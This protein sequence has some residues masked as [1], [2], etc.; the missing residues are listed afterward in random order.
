MDGGVRAAGRVKKKY[1]RLAKLNRIYPGFVRL[2]DFA[3]AERADVVRGLL[4]NAGTLHASEDVRFVTAVSLIFGGD[5]AVR[6]FEQLQDV[7]AAPEGEV[8]VT[9][10]GTG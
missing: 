3:E 1:H 9:V 6:Y 10:R 4:A 5:E 2:T 8:S 7:A